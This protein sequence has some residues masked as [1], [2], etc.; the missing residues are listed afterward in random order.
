M[1][2]RCRFCVIQEFSNTMLGY[3]APEVDNSPEYDAPWSNRVPPN[4]VDWR[5]KGGVTP[6]KNRMLVWLLFR[7]F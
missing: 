5:Q 4:D 2:E 1:A 7:Q 3:I 6:I